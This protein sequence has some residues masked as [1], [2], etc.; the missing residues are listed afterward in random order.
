MLSKKHILIFIGVVILAFF[1]GRC[2]DTSKEIVKTT[3]TIPEKTGSSVIITSPKPIVTTKD[4]IIY[5]DKVIT[6][7]SPINKK[8][9]QDYIDLEKR[10]SD[11][12]LEKERL[13][14]YLESIQVRDYSIPVEDEFL[15]TTN[16]VKVQGEL[17]SFQQDYKI[18]ERKVEVEVPVKK[19][20]ALY[21]GAE[22]GNTPE[23]DKFIV[24][25]NLMLQNKKGDILSASIDSEKRV[26][27]GYAIK[28]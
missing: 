24:K 19:R 26:W 23:L 1:I 14:K 22:I 12:E 25:G 17:I 18:K 8:L 10:Y 15:S 28:F 11:I 21:A 27:V 16:N 9:A 7:D 4:S 20:I 3:V 5:K 2:S 6:T 13:K